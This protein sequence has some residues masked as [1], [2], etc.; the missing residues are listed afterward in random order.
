MNQVRNALASSTERKTSTYARK[1]IL[2]QPIILKTRNESTDR[3]IQELNLLKRELSAIGSNFNQLV[4]NINTFK[5]TP[6]GRV[7]FPLA[8]ENQKKLVTKVSI[9]QEQIQQFVRLWLQK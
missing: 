7:W 3:F 9:I 1:L 6:E 8:L 2:G 5:D 4:K